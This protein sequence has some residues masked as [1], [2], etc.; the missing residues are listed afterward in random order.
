MSAEELPEHQESGLQ[1]DEVDRVELADNLSD[2]SEQLQRAADFMFNRQAADDLFERHLHGAEPDEYEQIKLDA[3]SADEFRRALTTLREFRRTFSRTERVIAEYAL[4]QMGYTQ[5][6]AAK[7]LGVGV[8]TINRWAQ[9]PVKI[10]EQ[11]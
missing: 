6:D 10:E 9:H 3:K 4:K 5:R 2:L 8:S 7:Y 1:V 11:D